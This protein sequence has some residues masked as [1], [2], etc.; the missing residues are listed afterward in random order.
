MIALTY[1]SKNLAER[2]DVQINNQ[3][4]VKWSTFNNRRLAI[5]GALISVDGYYLQMLEGPKSSVDDL[6]GRIAR[7]P[8]HADVTVTDMSERLERW[9]P[10]WSLAFAGRSHF[11]SVR[12]APLISTDP[13]PADVR[14]ILEIIRA[15]A[16]DA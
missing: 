6:M 13:R 3:D 7:D 16:R 5:T 1:V 2:D 14:T 12:I 8:R 10:D 15:F 4:I 11:A 9:F